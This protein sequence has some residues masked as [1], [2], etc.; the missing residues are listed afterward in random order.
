MQ[1]PFERIQKEK[2]C[3]NGYCAAISYIAGQFGKVL[4]ELAPL[5]IP[6]N[7]AKL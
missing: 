3:T 7:T 5:W 1:P 6:E 2:V 4:D